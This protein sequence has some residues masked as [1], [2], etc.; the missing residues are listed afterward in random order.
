MTSNAGSTDQSGATG[1]GK[2]PE[3]ASAD[4]EPE[5]P[6]GVPAPRVP[7]PRGRSHHLPPAERGGSGKDRRADA[8]RIQ[9]RLA[10]HSIT[11][12]YGQPALAAIVAQS[13]TKYGAR[14]LRR[15]I[16]KAVEDPIAEALVDGRLGATPATVE[17]VDRDGKPELTL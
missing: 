8:G 7:G 5:G 15:T 14:E 4:Q 2:R 11:L 12:N 10:A 17:L 9:T 6:A 3:T 16:R 13:S 1:F